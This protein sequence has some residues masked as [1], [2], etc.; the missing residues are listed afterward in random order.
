MVI[1]IKA[2]SGKGDVSDGY[3]STL[4]FFRIGMGEGS[5]LGDLVEQLDTYVKKDGTTKMTGN[6]DMGNKKVVKLLAPTDDGD[7]ATKKYVDSMTVGDARPAEFEFTYL[8]GGSRDPGTTKFNFNSFDNTFKFNLSASTA[9]IYINLINS[10][11]FSGDSGPLISIYWRDS[12]ARWFT[13]LI[14]PVIG[15]SIDSPDSSSQRV[16]NVQ[17]ND[18]SSDDHHWVN[19]W[20][21]VEIAMWSLYPLLVCS[22]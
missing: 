9:E 19:K 22:K 1:D 13:R 14:T 11:T 17:V 2:M 6:L 8:G 15:L 21:E 12:Q 7:A 16:L 3:E 10:M 18:V 4:K 20:S 5:D